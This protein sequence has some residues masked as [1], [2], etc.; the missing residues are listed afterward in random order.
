MV[1]KYMKDIQKKPKANITNQESAAQANEMQVRYAEVLH[2]IAMIGFG[3]LLLTF[4]IY[5]S[6]ILPSLVPPE[7]VPQMWHMEAEEYVKV[8]HIPIG[9]KWIFSLGHGDILAFASLIFL[10]AGTIFCFIITL[11]SFLKRR[12]FIY[13]AIIAAEILV[14]LLAASGLVSGGH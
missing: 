10:A 1:K 13:S 12:E 3:L 8:N 11:F 5:I 6:G 7:K 4:F 9:W 2:W 14:L